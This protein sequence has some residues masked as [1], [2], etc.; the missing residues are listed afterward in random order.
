MFG[1]Y[2]LSYQQYQ[3][4]YCEISVEYQ[5]QDQYQNLNLN[6]HIIT[7]IE[8]KFFVF[9][10]KILSPYLIRIRRTTSK[11]HQVQWQQIPISGSTVEWLQF[12]QIQRTFQSNSPTYFFRLL[13]SSSD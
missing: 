3:R 5:D 13:V 1:K 11:Y 7:S 2:F 9:I 12:S 10:K 8:Y 4:C 6:T